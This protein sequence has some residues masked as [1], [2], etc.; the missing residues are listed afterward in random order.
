[1]KFEY[2]MMQ[3]TSKLLNVY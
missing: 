3:R 2:K 1:M